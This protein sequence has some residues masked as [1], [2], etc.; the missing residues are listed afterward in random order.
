GEPTDPTR[1]HIRSTGGPDRAC[2]YGGEGGPKKRRRDDAGAAEDEAP[3]REL[4]DGLLAVSLEGERSAA[5]DDANQRD[6]EWQIQGDAQSGE[7]G[8]ERGEEADQQK[9]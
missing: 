5:Q 8:G 2:G 7:D 1:G 6:R 3:G 9:D 4:A